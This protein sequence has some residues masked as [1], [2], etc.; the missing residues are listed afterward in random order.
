LKNELGRELE[1]SV[2]L[3][4]E[5]KQRQEYDKEMEESRDLRIKSWHKFST[6]IG[7]K[8]KKKVLPGAI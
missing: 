7:K 5:I 1:A 6:K 2:K 4:Q 8:K 3:E